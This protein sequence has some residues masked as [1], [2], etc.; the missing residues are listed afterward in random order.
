MQGA[1][2]THVCGK[3]K[4]ERDKKRRSFRE[5]QLFTR[6]NGRG[7]SKGARHPQPPLIPPLNTA[8]STAVSIRPFRI[9]KGKFRFIRGRLFFFFPGLFGPRTAQMENNAT[10]CSWQLLPPR[11]VSLG[12]RDS[13]LSILL[14]FPFEIFVYL[15]RA[16]GNSTRCPLFSRNQSSGVFTPLF[17]FAIL[18][19]RS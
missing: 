1:R 12:Q 14:S 11:N 5:R 6:L 3:W 2:N 17:K 15:P 8:I 19:R 13:F 9:L 16:A 7:S 4:R 10:F 18:E